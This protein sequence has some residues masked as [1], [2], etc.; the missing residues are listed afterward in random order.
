MHAKN[1]RAPTDSI[2]L[3][4]RSGRTTER[5]THAIA[6]SIRPNVT[7][8]VLPT[9]AWKRCTLSA[10]KTMTTPAATATAVN[11]TK[12]TVEYEPGDLWG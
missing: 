8:A 4:M 1:P 12:N 11:R 7:A 9:E 6:V 2:A 3:P 5:T 10:S